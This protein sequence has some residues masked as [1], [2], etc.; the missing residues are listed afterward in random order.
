MAR[1]A[2]SFLTIPAIAGA[3]FLTACSKN[4]QNEMTSPSQ[5]PRSTARTSQN[6]YNN[7]G[8][9][10]NGGLAAISAD[11][12]VLTLTAS[13]K[14]D[15][16]QNY[17]NAQTG[18]TTIPYSSVQATDVYAKGGMV[19]L[20]SFPDNNFHSNTVS[21]YLPTD[22]KTEIHSLFDALGLVPGQTIGAVK[23]VVDAQDDI[24]TFETHVIQTYG[25]YSTP[26]NSILD[27]NTNEGKS[28]YLL[29]AAAV[30]KYSYQY[31]DSVANDPGHP[32][33]IP[34]DTGCVECKPFWDTKFGH[35]VAAAGRDCVG[36]LD[37]FEGGEI[38]LTTGEKT[39]LKY[40]IPKGIKGA[41]EAS[42]K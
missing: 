9:L 21:G 20:F 13:Q 41:V 19:N 4:D 38:N 14:F 10:H 2:L 31:W 37:G 28:T 35:I 11:P 7:V 27:L 36:L 24:E 32:W 25:L 39:D 12:N 26:L 30:A 33:N 3:I 42:S 34:A 18:W 40:N 15:V 22:L 5:T 29:M 17:L 8:E 16:A 6:P 23:S 1:K